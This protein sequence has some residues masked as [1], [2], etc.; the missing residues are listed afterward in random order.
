[1]T[2]FGVSIDEVE[3][4]RKQLNRLRKLGIELDELSYIKNKATGF[5]NHLFQLCMSDFNGNIESYKTD[6]E[7]L[8]ETV[9]NRNPLTQKIR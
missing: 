7:K 3:N 6:L 2:Y 8:I 9:G 1:M 5:E 4:V